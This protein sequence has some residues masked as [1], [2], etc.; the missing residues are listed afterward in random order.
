ML[1]VDES[2][3]RHIDGMSD[4]ESRA[5]LDYLFQHL[6][7]PEYQMRLAW[8]K[9]TVVLWDNRCA[10]HYAI[11][12]YHPRHRLVHRVTVLERPRG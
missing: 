2:F 4:S 11:A 3:T 9:D 6:R 7:T 12:D 8:A 5:L 10:V 1:F